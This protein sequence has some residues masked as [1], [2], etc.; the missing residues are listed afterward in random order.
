MQTALETLYT[1]TCRADFHVATTLLQKPRFPP[2]NLPHMQS[3]DSNS[4]SHL[5]TDLDRLGRVNP[6][7]LDILFSG[8]RAL[9]S[10]LRTLPWQTTTSPDDISY[11]DRVYYLQRH[12]FDIA[13]DTSYHAPLDSV[14][15]LAALMYCGYRLRDIPFAYARVSNAVTRLKDA[16]EEYEGSHLWVGDGKLATKMI[17]LSAFGG[18]ASQ[19]KPERTWFAERFRMCCENLLIS[20]WVGAK[21][22]LDSV[23]WERELDEGGVR[24]WNES[25]SRTYTA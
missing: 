19:G 20:D 18:V 21:M 12:L 1:D 16:I 15:A 4:S 2:L 13:Q 11:S 9:S 10:T 25:K 7:G 6:P 17:W 5:R 3:P 22:V 14:C 24:L 8:L 23:L